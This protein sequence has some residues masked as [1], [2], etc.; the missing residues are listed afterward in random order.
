ALLVSRGYEVFLPLRRLTREWSD[1]IR[2][3]SAP[4]F[5][6][7]LFCKFDVVDRALIATN[8]GVIQI[9]GDGHR[10]VPVEPAEIQALQQIVASPQPFDKYAF[11]RTGQ[12]VS[13]HC[14]PLQG[15][16]GFLV[17][18]E[19]QHKVVVSISLMQRSVAV[20]MPL[21]WITP[22]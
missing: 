4:L 22:L 7:Y 18:A 10:P 2:Q 12:E 11:L 20:Q 21:E 8:P 15:L 14:G 9:L 19:N 16:T 3:V 13:V 17:T 5:P 1:R 6:R